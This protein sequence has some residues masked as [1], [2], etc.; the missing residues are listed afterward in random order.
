MRI[1][2]ANKPLKLLISSL[3]MAIPSILQVIMVT[4]LFLI[5]LGLTGVSFF[6]GGFYDCNLD[7]TGFEGEK[8]NANQ[9]A[10]LL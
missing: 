8:A 7:A 10:S 3:L 1:V 6:K 9:I 5:V 2:S 4:L